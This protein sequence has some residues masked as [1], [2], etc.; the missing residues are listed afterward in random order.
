M[1]TLYF[2]KTFGRA[3]DAVTIG[4][5]WTDVADV[6]MTST[7]SITGV[8]TFRVGTPCS[9]LRDPGCVDHGVV[10]VCSQLSGVAC[11]PHVWWPGAARRRLAS[12]DDA[13]RRLASSDNA[14]RRLSGTGF[15][16]TRLMSTWLLPDGTRQNMVSWIDGDSNAFEAWFTRAP[17]SEQPPLTNVS[18]RARATDTRASRSRSTILPL[19]IPAALIKRSPRS[20]RF[21]K[22][23]I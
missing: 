19:L 16:Y 10:S 5:E 12:S 20:S 8:G 1:N 21:K 14:R 6:V 3:S 13:P 2:N 23:F 7:T 18:R 22:V 9:P 17:G 15:Y 4:S 11:E